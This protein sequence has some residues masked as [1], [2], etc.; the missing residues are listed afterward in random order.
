MAVVLALLLTREATRQPAVRRAA[1]QATR[2]ALGRPVRFASEVDARHFQKGNVHTHSLLSDGKAPLEAMVAWYR[3]HGYQFLAMTEHNQRVA[4]ETLGWMENDGFV[5]IAGEE[6]TNKWDGT[7]LHVNALCARSGIGGGIDYARAESGI[8]EV[9]GLIRQRGGV[10]LLDH[11]NFHFALDA[12]QIESGASGF[13]LFEIWSGHPDVN[14]SGDVSHPS[15][16][17]IWDD[18]L[19]RGADAAPVAVDDA[20]ELA[21][22]PGQ[23]AALPGRGWV[24]TFGGETS[25]AAICAA[26]ADGQVYAS[27]GPSLTEIRVAGE[28]F[29]VGVDRAGGARCLP[30]RGGRDVGHGAAFGG[31]ALG[32]V[33]L[34]RLRSERARRRHQPRERS[35]MDRRVP[36]VSDSP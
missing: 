21:A 15:A 11:P 31:A 1:R 7:P 3:D 4:P 22:P 33:P 23:L 5:V 29:T 2:A 8:A 18:L 30:R 32:D 28:T 17:A 26:L 24:E 14:P 35:R 6:L 13:Y 20:H 12:D 34:D 9:F 19:A 27:S 25:R 10:P 16:E 36:A